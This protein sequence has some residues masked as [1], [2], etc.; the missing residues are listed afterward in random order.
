M[1]FRICARAEIRGSLMRLP[2]GA[3]AHLRGSWTPIATGFAI[4]PAI[5]RRSKGEDLRGSIGREGRSRTK[6]AEE[7][8]KRVQG[9]SHD[10]PSLTS[11]SRPYG[12]A[13]R[14][15][16]FAKS[17]RRPKSR[18]AARR[19]TERI[20]FY[21]RINQQTRRA[22]S[23]RTRPWNLGVVSRRLANC[24]APAGGGGAAWPRG[25]CTADRAWSSLN[26]SIQPSERPFRPPLTRTRPSPSATPSTAFTL[27]P[28]SNFPSL[29]LP[30]SLLR[31]GVHYTP[32]GL[33]SPFVCA[34]YE[35]QKRTV[36]SWCPFDR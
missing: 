15:C 13:L 23:Q 6:R 35:P 31:Y 34:V 5:L 27:R 32:P 22:S 2:R 19:S 10:S 20:N 8:G 1:H 17:A 26:L 18:N 11:R 36:T 14:D 21:A 29:S 9:E 4:S 12:L 24:V 33:R 7:N 25:W 28:L 30:L 16:S 3:T